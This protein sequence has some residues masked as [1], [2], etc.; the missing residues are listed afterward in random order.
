MSLCHCWKLVETVQRY[1]PIVGILKRQF[2]T[3]VNGKMRK[4][5]QMKGHKIT[6][7]RNIYVLCVCVCLCV[8]VCVDIVAY[9]LD[10]DDTTF[11]SLWRIIT[12]NCFNPATS[13]YSLLDPPG[14]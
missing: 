3:Y 10:L 12:G 1:H 11:L 9:S 8:Y 6:K 5:T 2:F 4:S 7:E 13:P 14:K